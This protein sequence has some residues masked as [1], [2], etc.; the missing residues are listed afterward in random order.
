MST[1]LAR[2]RTQQ[3]TDRSSVGCLARMRHAVSVYVVVM[4]ALAA[5]MTL[6][7]P[8]RAAYEII[9]PP[10][11]F[12]WNGGSI[13]SN[14]LV[15][16]YENLRFYR[17][18]P[19]GTAALNVHGSHFASADSLG[20]T[21]PTILGALP[22]PTDAQGVA[23][24]ID[25]LVTL[26][27]SNDFSAGEALFLVLE[28]PQLPASAFGTRPDGL[29]IVGVSASITSAGVTSDYLIALVE[30]TSGSNTFVG[31]LQNGGS[32]PI[33]AN[34]T[35]QINYQNYGDVDD[36]LTTQAPYYV[37][38]AAFDA[39]QGSK[40]ARIGAAAAP[41]TGAL[42]VSKQALRDTVSQGELVSYRILVANRGSADLTGI[43]L[44]DVL[45]TGFRIQAESI[46]RNGAPLQP[47]A[48]TQKRVS[49]PV[50]SLAAGEKA[51]IEYVAEAT[52]QAQPGKAI[53]TAVASSNGGV[54]SNTAQAIVT[55]EQ[56]FLNDRAF[57]MG[58]VVIGQCGDRA[59]AGMAGARL[60]LEDGSSVITDD[61][62]RWHLEGIKPGTHVLQ[63]DSDSL[64]PR[65]TVRQCADHSR[66]AG[67]TLSRFVDL[68]GGT[69]WR[70]TFYLE[71]KPEVTAHIQQQL[72]SD[73]ENGEVRI[74]LPLGNGDTEFKTVTVDF[75]LPDTLTPVPGSAALDGREIGDPVHSDNFY[76]LTLKPKG[77]Y[78]ASEVAL[79]LRLDPNASGAN[80][81]TV[82]V[83]TS[84]ITPAGD[85]HTVQS[86]NEL[87]LVSAEMHEA[88]L[89]LRPTF[90]SMSAAL[91]SNDLMVIR[92]AA[93]FLESFQA[94]EL[95]IVGHTDSRRVRRREGRLINDNETLAVARAQSVADALN[96]YLDLPPDALRVS[97]RG[98]REPIASND[99]EKGRALNRRVEITI[100]TRERVRDAQLTV[101]NGASGIDRAGSRA[102]TNMQDSGPGFRNLSD[103]MHISIPVVSVTGTLDERLQ[104]RLLLN[105]NEVPAERLGMKIPDKDAGQ[106][107]YT[108]LGLELPDTGDYQLELQG[109]GPFGNTRFSRAITLTRTS[110]IKRIRAAT[111]VEN[112]ADGKTPIRLP[113]TIEDMSGR[114]IQSRVEL[115]LLNGDLTPMSIAGRADDLSPQRAVV[116]VDSDG[117]AWFEPVATAGTYRIQLG[118][119]DDVASD[120]LEVQVKP[121]LRDWIMVGFARG[122]I[123]HSTLED[124]ISALPDAEEDT[125]TDGEAAFFARGRIK[126]E[127]LLTMAYDSRREEDDAPLGGQFDPNQ[128]YVLYGDSAQRQQEAASSEKLYL[129]IERDNFYALF[130]DYDTDLTVTELSRYQRTLTGF[131]TELRD[132]NISASL[133]AAQTAQAYVR[134][135]IRGDGTSGLYRLGDRDI[136]PG[137]ETVRIEVRDRFN[138]TLVKT[139][140]RARYLDY[141][142]DYT[143]GTLFFR[144]P[145]LSQDGDFNPVFIVVEYELDNGR[146]NT[147][148]GGRVAIHDSGKTL[149]LGVTAIHEGTE[150]REA[151][152]QGIDLTWKPDDNHEVR[153]EMAGTERQEDATTD[154]DGNAWLGEYLY[155]SSR[156][157]GRVRVEQ[158]DAD[159]GIGQQAASESGA[160][161]VSG[162]VR[163]RI[164]EHYTVESE[165]RRQT[166]LGADQ[167][168]DSVE[169]RL[170][171]HRDTLKVWGGART[172]RDQIGAE[173]YDS[174]LA[175]AGI[176]QSFLDKRVTL[177]A[178]GE[179]AIGGEARNNDYP[180]KLTL[181]ADYRV[182]AIAT[183]FASQELAWGEEYRA[184]E[185]RV[186]SRI[187]PWK[188]GTLV[189]DVGHSEDE[190]GPRLFSHAGLYQRLQ[191]SARWSA[192]LAMDRAQT[193]HD[194]TRN[195]G[196]DDA[197]RDP[198]SGT[199][200]QDYTALA[201]G[202]G[203]RDSV[204]QWNGRIEN[205]QSDI[206]DKW[207]LLSA[208][209][210]RL[211]GANTVIGRLSHRD[212]KLH[213]GADEWETALELSLSHRPDASPWWMLNRTRLV[214][215]GLDDDFGSRHGQRL[216][217]NL[218]GNFSA[219]DYHQLA[220]MYG[221][222]YVREAIRDDS[223]SGYS[224]L[225]SGE[226]R[227][228]IGRHWDI[229][230][231]ASLL[232]SH[233]SNVSDDS[234]G[235]MVGVSPVRDVWISLGYNFRGFYDADFDQANS[236]VAGVVLDFRIKFDQN[237]LRHWRDDERPRVTAE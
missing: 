179:T 211:D 51:I 30:T 102:S 146:E 173:Q 188:G 111:P 6:P 220:L 96:T 47:T 180:N 33:P 109:I 63:L 91:N 196:F 85:V 236:R 107:H 8:A 129:R 67:N 169:G 49:V 192:D 159:F 15:T 58:R 117:V 155:Q 197:R 120:T 219:N 39:Q 193:L 167:Q 175:L 232:T 215:D 125:Y 191:L 95:D 127:W 131:K 214:L 229:G 161:Q 86:V 65:Y 126:G 182:N 137:S 26:T 103:G 25:Q 123:G 174:D 210:H 194:G 69:L 61:Q 5:A 135:D 37:A 130:G 98:Q 84:G 140:S 4:L 87:G 106:I 80:R 90:A 54:T 41:G 105:G 116:Q 177:R 76:R 93:R 217:N 187:T 74:R 68:Q 222:R 228:H 124:N 14:V 162:E 141:S 225:V 145:V 166:L 70:E 154:V 168:R 171:Y 230:A 59:G 19:S 97:G 163:Y 190:F 206:S 204:W 189:S 234:Y 150:G 45:P 201:A 143:D 138:N 11:T 212:E 205:R 64:G 1:W 112:V 149:E 38:L 114:E 118:A 94:V 101:V 60:Y 199:D 78:W 172:A 34:S 218:T 32:L 36:Q 119:N 57:L 203:Y 237:S 153:V 40:Q 92:E 83:R 122:S 151:D 99:T 81:K 227:Y 216:V 21:T 27:P 10:A 17:Y 144:E 50:G 9:Q 48:L 134:R 22:A 186:G 71:E 178:S 209:H 75:F 200:S 35:I 158:Q 20:G 28:Q 62:G 31:Y 224:D 202:L 56:A 82:L 104:P 223:Y 43:S 55:V 148:G 195:P 77:R 176:S 46:R 164:H 72:F 110:D 157:D 128:W 7:A 88:T 183:L 213:G 44:D 24:A 42:F 23:I 12:N 226:Y 160:R 113:L 53:N 132:D 147:S 165:A 185:S 121:A 29:R 100:R 18:D 136:V 208:L 231:R 2:A 52:V 156:L 184:L 13:Q 235:V 221:A 198:A 108:W 89:T 207:N 66:S 152:L 16:R 73:I 115:R 3:N 79:S 233:R 133:F 170:N 181:G 139:E 142:I